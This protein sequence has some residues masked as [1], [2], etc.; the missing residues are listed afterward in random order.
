MTTR[1]RALTDW[2]TV[3]PIVAVAV[4]A[5]TFGRN[6]PT[7]AAVVVGIVLMSAVLAAVQHAEVIAHRVGEPYGSLVLALAVTVI[8]AGLILTLVVSGGD[9]A[10]TLARDTVFS[11][12]MICLNG[13]VGVSLLVGS[14]RRKFVHFN[15]EGAGAAL[16]TLATLA[17]LC[18][19]VPTY[20]TTVPGPEFSGSQL[21]FAALAS[22]ALWAAFVANQTGR[23]RDFF[24]PVTKDGRILDEDTHADPPPTSA[25]WRSAALLIVALVGV[26]GLAKVVSPNIESA[27]TGAGLP[28]AFV[29]VIIAMVV[30]LPES[31]A[32]TT[33]ARRRRFQTSLNLAYGSSIATIGLTI[34]TVAA[35]TIW[36][37]TPLHLGLSSLQ[38]ALLAITL[39]VSVLTVVP[40]RATRLE[41]VVHLVLF[42]A[43]VFLAATP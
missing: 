14:W 22:L 25:A 42:A 6:L 37:D 32:A 38:V 24:L 40:G 39:I 43:F 9:S 15:A 33:A 26:V 20:T 4:L 16:A 2:T 23:H 27:V 10:S 21:A 12:A 36:I 1:L 41:G 17:A 30:L 18:L 13:I 3:L 35:A 29:G 34:P 11:A 31:I 19:V 7:A 5:A 28:A 8:E